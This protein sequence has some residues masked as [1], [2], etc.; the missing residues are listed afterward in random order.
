MSHD[1]PLREPRRERPC[2]ESGAFLPNVDGTGVS[3]MRRIRRSIGIGRCGV[4]R[5]SRALVSTPV[6]QF[7][8]SLMAP[9]LD[10]V[11]DRILSGLSLDWR[12]RTGLGDTSI[13][14]AA[15]DEQG[16]GKAVE[17]EAEGADDDDCRD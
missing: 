16:V 11:L 3:T 5:E 14:S 12:S 10:S 15:G 2:S 7:E 9:G 1:L 6:F 4:D 8:P 13:G 17:H